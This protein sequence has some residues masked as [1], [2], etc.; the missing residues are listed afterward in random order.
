MYTSCEPKVSN[1]NPAAADA[2]DELGF[3]SAVEAARRIRQGEL[4]PVDY[5]RA[6]LDRIARHDPNLNAFIRIT[7]DAALDAAR[8]SEQR[9]D[10]GQ[11]D[12]PMHGVPFALKDIVDAA[13]L[14]TTCHS[15]LLAEN[16]AGTDAEVTRRLKAAGAILV[17]KLATHEFALGGPCFDLPWPP[18]RNPWDRT[19]FTGGSS[20]GSGAAVAAGLVPMAIGTD[21]AGSVRNP[22][23]ACGIVGMKATYGAVSRRGVF[24]LSY[25]LDH[26][27]PMTRTVTENA[28]ML[29]VLAGHDPG[30]PGSAR[31]PGDDYTRALTHGVEGLRIGAV[32]HFYTRD[33]EADPEVAAA[34]DAALQTLA[35]LGAEIVEVETRSLDEFRECNR[36]I[37]LSE[38][39]AVH[40]A[41]L[42]SRP[43]D[44]AALTRERLAGGAFLRAVD[45]VQA[46][47]M[48]R[49]LTDAMHEAMQGVDVL[50]TVSSH[51]PPCRI[52]DT[53]AV[54]RTYQRQARAPFNLT[55]QPALA[56]PCG[57]TAEERLPMGI[58]I[59]G[60]DFDE[61]LVYR[62]A[63][64]YER[65]SEW[66]HTRPEL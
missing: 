45:Y 17:G 38:A 49:V 21:T 16:V 40:E 20:S 25:S 52:D 10:A 32:R 24:P 27:G 18:A 46:T 44:Y 30:D 64:A 56:M 5:T 59:V 2:S 6:L 61:A 42:Q 50:L 48:R 43:E 47:R 22:A 66:R 53:D 15:K 13:G 8:K 63:Y 57:F 54:A 28:A 65:A 58:Q 9:R 60:R 39:Y 11:V 12:G 33:M 37:L 3:L 4:S 29:S 26:V 51:D 34:V 1:P 14:P 41:W 31:V 35:E 55:G 36:I 7:E 23:T 62:V 19:R